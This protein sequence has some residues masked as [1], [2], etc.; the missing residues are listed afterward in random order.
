MPKHYYQAI[1]DIMN[2]SG[3]TEPV[4]IQTTGNMKINVWNI[5]LYNANINIGYK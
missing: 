1:H 3:P 2:K 5:I 4:E